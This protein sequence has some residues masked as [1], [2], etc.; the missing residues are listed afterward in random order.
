MNNSP[1]KTGLFGIFKFLE[2]FQKSSTI[3][4]VVQLFHNIEEK[5]FTGF[6]CVG[7]KKSGLDL[8][9]LKFLFSLL[10]HKLKSRKML[11]TIEINRFFDGYQIFGKY[12]FIESSFTG[13]SEVILKEL[14]SSNKRSRHS[15]V[16][17]II[18]SFVL[19]LYFMKVKK[20]AR[21]LS[22]SQ[23]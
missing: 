18:A 19:R 14:G 15:F 16:K 5:K 7:L 1:I 17:I 11:S 12:K 20:I 22:K 10:M 23:D 13:S 8:Y 2:H 21:K 3:G 6:D 4:R 9:I